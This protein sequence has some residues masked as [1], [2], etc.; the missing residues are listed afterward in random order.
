M[1]YYQQL[2]IP[3][4]P[5]ELLAQLSYANQPMWRLDYNQRW[6]RNGQQVFA[7]L[8]QNFALPNPEICA[9]IRDHV[10]PECVSESINQA[11]SM[12]THPSQCEMIPHVD[13]VRPRSLN[14][15]IENGSDENQLTWYQEKGYP[16]ERELRAAGQYTAT[17]EGG[18]ELDNLTEVASVN[19][20]PNSWYWIRTDII[21]GVKNIR[22]NRKFITVY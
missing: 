13:M 8:Y 15:Y 1:Q 18:L 20:R 9:W 22:S 10:P 21:H 6:Y 3:P 17:R 5:A 7:P 4:I 2:D 19:C 16:I 12:S 11:H 14:Y